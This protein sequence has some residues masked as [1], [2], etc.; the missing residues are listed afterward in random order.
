VPGS[1]TRAEWIALAAW[2]AVG[3]LF[4]FGRPRSTR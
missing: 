4:W 2:S 1:F 3:F